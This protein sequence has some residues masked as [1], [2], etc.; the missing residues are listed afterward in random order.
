MLLA[1][2]FYSFSIMLTE[3]VLM[4]K[5]NPQIFKL[6]KQYIQIYDINILKL[7]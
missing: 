3:R 4:L 6:F 2:S 1:E 5:R 7:Y